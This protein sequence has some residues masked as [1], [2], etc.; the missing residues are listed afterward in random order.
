MQ[1]FAPAAREE[2]KT[3]FATDFKGHR[4][5]RQR[6]GS[7]SPAHCEKREMR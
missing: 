3:R 4:Q 1:T 5:K 2:N 7:L 6:F